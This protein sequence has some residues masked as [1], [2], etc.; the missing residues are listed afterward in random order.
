MEHFSASLFSS[1]SK[2]VWFLDAS[3]NC[4]VY[5]ITLRMRHAC[6]SDAMILGS[7]TVEQAAVNR[8]VTGSNPVRGASVCLPGTVIDFSRPRQKCEVFF[9]GAT[10]P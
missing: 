9:V 5:S 3:R 10:E 1:L 8:K 7:S 6:L 2:R 4:C